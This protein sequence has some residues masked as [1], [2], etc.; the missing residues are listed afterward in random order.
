MNNSMKFFSMLAMAVGLVCAWTSQAECAEYFVSKDGDNS[1]SGTSTN[2]WLTIQKSASAAVA[3]DIVTVINGE[4]DEVVAISSSGTSASSVITFRAQNLHE[5]KCRGFVISG[6]YILIDGFEIEAEGSN[7]R[8]VRVNGATG[9]SIRNCHV[10]DCPMGGIDVTYGASNA[11]VVDNIL[12]H[13]GQWGIQVIGSNVLIEGNE[14]FDTVQYHDKGDEPGFTGND[15]DGL[16]IFGDHHTIRSNY[17]HDIADPADSTHNIDPHADCIQT[18]DES[19]PTGRPVMTDTLIERNHCRIEHATGKGVMMSAIHDD[20]CREITIRN[21]VFEFRDE[22]I[23][24]SLGSFEN[25]YVYNNVFKATLDDLSWGVAVY[26]VD[27]DGYEV[28][29]NIMVDCHTQARKIEGGSGTVDYNL[30]W[31]SD[32]SSPGGPPTAQA[33]ELWGVDPVFVSYDGSYGGDYRLSSGS[34]AIDTGAILADVTDDHVGTIRPQGNGYDI[35]AFEY[36]EGADA[37]TDTDTDTDN[38]TDSNVD[39]G[40]LDDGADDGTCGCH[41]IG[42]GD[43]HS[44]ILSVLVRV[45]SK[46]RKP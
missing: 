45:A 2:P 15:A 9:V 11:E 36:H 37:D 25:I 41:A 31:N 43:L 33:N 24:A 4:Y 7:Y 46:G 38:S 3:G 14:I 42:A 12:E 22:G 34:P 5:A 6:D 8:G 27:V 17:I 26:M 30:A 23:A 1:A 20:T 16:R 18:F 28:I 32:G 35:G 19:S 29:N 44:G 21:N 10:H 39:G 40:E 13:N